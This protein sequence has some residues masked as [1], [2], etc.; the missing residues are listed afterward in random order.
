MADVVVI[1]AGISGAAAAFELTAAGVSVVL[2]DRYA[3]AAMASGWTLAG[4]RQSGRHP[5]ELPLARS[6]VAL[7][8]DL[9]EALGADT[10][11]RRRGNLRIARS[12]AEVP[13]IERLV[14]E[15]VAAGLD[16]VLL[17]EAAD[18]RAVAPSVRT[19]AVLVASLCASDG[20][21]DPNAT[22]RAFVTAALRAGAT[23]RFGERVLAIEAVA[24]KV[25][26]VRTDKGMIRADRVVVAAGIF[27]N[28][29]LAPLG[30]AVPLDIQ[31]V[32]VLQSAPM[33][34]L[35]EQ[36]IGVANADVA[37]RQEVG[38]RFRVTSGVEP[39]DKQMEDGA[40]PTVRPTAA[41]LAGTVEKFGRLVPAFA[42]ARIEAIWGR[43]DRYDPGRAA[44]DRG[45]AGD[46]RPGD[47]NGIFRPRLLPRTN[48][49][50]H[51][52][53]PRAGTGPGA[54][55]RRVPAQSLRRME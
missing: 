15:Q 25:R 32:S 31:V 39:W 24:G 46:R 17:R 20:H 11:Y 34:A 48:H 5:A 30:L 40:M 42:A 43:P 41:G 13:V 54:A 52:G 21:A 10:F 37:G 23:T 47:R 38:G 2:V 49:G 16:I 4:V 3:P 28:E 7:W 35:L 9:H 8:Q 29:L 26:G 6:A 55:A 45:H 50:P 36:V 19:D 44:G 53:P 51:S 12:E 18:I 33:P 27:A 14:E 22:V 1:G